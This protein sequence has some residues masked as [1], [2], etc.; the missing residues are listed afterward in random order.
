MVRRAARHLKHARD[1]AT[2]RTTRPLGSSALGTVAPTSLI[3]VH[4]RRRHGMY[5]R[6]DRFDEAKA[7]A[8]KILS[9][10]EDTETRYDPKSLTRALCLGDRYQ[11]M[12]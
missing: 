2:R 12:L 1:F 10:G 7:V 6:L 11:A 9:Q 5:R 4:V 8:E 3:S